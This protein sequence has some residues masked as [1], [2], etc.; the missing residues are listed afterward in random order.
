MNKFLSTILIFLLLSTLTFAQETGKTGTDKLGNWLMYFGTN[1]ISEKYSIHSEAQLRLY[2]S[3]SNFNQLLLRVGV[4]YHLSPNMIVTAGYGYI[5]TESFAKNEFKNETL[6]HRLWQQLIL[7]SSFG[8]LF[9]DH[10]YR[11]EQRWIS[12][13]TDDKYLNR[14]R[15]RFMVNIPLNRA[16]MDDNTLFISFY[17]EIFLNVI[18]NPFDQNRLYG[19][20]GYKFNK[21]LSLQAGYL[22][23]TLG[24]SAYDRLQVGIFFNTDFSKSTPN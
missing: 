4:N 21:S 15:Y 18:E 12:S 11:V 20:L 16:S 14:I 24:S 5:P 23:H 9:F 7:T 10:R 13:D 8:R 19:A 3:A 6:E 1:K 2:Q 17:D 22:K